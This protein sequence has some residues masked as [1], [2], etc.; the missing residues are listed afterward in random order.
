M[1]FF[2]SSLLLFIF[3]PSGSR[4]ALLSQVDALN[5]VHATKFMLQPARSFVFHLVKCVYQAMP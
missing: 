1:Y 5:K 2:F 4:P 3:L